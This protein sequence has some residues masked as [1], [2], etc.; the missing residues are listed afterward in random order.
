MRVTRYSFLLIVGLMLT[1][2]ISTAFAS[3]DDSGKKRP[4]DAG[5]LSIR[6]TEEAFPVKI[7]GVERGMTGVGTPAEYYLTP[8]THTVEVLG[9]NGKIWKSQI[10]IRRG[11][12]HCVCRRRRG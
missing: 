6:T 5:T 7:D 1:I 9:P 12:K 4:K 10:E 2:G 8:G 11:Q 3:A